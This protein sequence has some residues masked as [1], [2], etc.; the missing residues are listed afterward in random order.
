M[1]KK[2]NLKFTIHVESVKK[3]FTLEINRLY[4]QN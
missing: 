3:R 1:H 2:I 4:G